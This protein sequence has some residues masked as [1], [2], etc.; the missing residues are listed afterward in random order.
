MAVIPRRQEVAKLF[1][2]RPAPGPN[3]A[4][5]LD[6]PAKQP[7][8]EQRQ[9]ALDGPRSSPSDARIDSGQTFTAVGGPSRSTAIRHAADRSGF[10]GLFRKGSISEGGM[11]SG[12]IGFAANEVIQPGA[13]R[14]GAGSTDGTVGGH[15]RVHASVRNNRNTR[16]LHGF[17][18][19]RCHTGGACE[20]WSPGARPDSRGAPE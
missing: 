6:V 9:Y 14:E 12:A 16:A 11:P 3:P 17:Q 4:R 10:N 8:E 5:R 15:R 7:R 19:I 20:K 18:A 13:P 1:P 2:P